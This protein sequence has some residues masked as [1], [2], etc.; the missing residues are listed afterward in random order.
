MNPTWLRRNQTVI[1]G[2]TQVAMNKISCFILWASHFQALPQLSSDDNGANLLVLGNVRRTVNS[3][4]T[5]VPGRDCISYWECWQQAVG[6]QGSC[7]GLGMDFS[8]LNEPDLDLVILVCILLIGMLG[9]DCQPI[10]HHD[11]KKKRVYICIYKTSTRICHGKASLARAALE[12]S[13][14]Q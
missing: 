7:H 10:L 1:L 8:A 6:L 9:W 13:M 5:A 12:T 2:R 4:L 3:H 11:H 14:L